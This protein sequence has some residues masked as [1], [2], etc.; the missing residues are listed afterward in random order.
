MIKLKNLIKEVLG[1]REFEHDLIDIQSE[2][3]QEWWSGQKHQS[4]KLVPARDLIITWNTFVKYGRADK[5]RVEKIWDIVKK[6][7]IKMAVNSDWWRNSDGTDLFGKENPDEITSQDWERFA[8]FMSDRSGSNLWRGTGDAPGGQGRYSDVINHLIDLLLQG[9]SAT[10]PE[11]RLLSI[12]KILMVVHGSGSI[13]KWYIEGGVSTLNKLRDIDVKGIKLQGKLSESKKPNSRLGLCYELSGRYVSGHPESILVHGKITNPFAKGLPEVEHAWIEIGN[14]ILDPVMDLTWPKNIYEDFF[15]AKI[16]KKYSFM[17]TI[18]IT[19]KTGNWGPWEELKESMEDDLKHQK[20]LQSTGFWGKRGAGALIMARTTGRILLQLRGDY[21]EQPRTWGVWGGAID[22][23]LSPESAMKQEI[24]QES[25]LKNSQI[26]ETT[27]LYVFSH[28]NGFKYYNFLII[29]DN[30]FIPKPS[31]SAEFEMNGFRWIEYGQWPSPLHF[32]LK[33]LLQ[34]SGNKIKKI[35]DRN[36]KGK[37][38]TE[39]I[40]KNHEKAAIEAIRYVWRLMPSEDRF[41]EYQFS[42]WMSNDEPTQDFILELAKRLYPEDSDAFYT[43]FNKDILPTLEKL[44]TIRNERIKRKI[45]NDPLFLLKM[46]VKN[47]SWE[48]AKQSLMTVSPAAGW[49]YKGGRITD[50]EAEQMFNRLYKIAMGQTMYDE[51]YIGNSPRLSDL[52]TD[53]NNVQETLFIHHL[54]GW[55]AKKFPDKVKVYRGTNSPL[56]KIRPGDFV[57]F[58]KDYARTYTKSKFG[59]VQQDILLAKD[60]RVFKMDPERD[61]MIYWPEGHAIKQVTDIPTFKEFWNSWRY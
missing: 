18:K 9:Y 55:N 24:E 40:D 53:H 49:G 21:V 48:G 56:A 37:I 50:N 5:N 33:L 23:G 2:M 52:S 28:P 13:A 31:Q 25:G 54:S 34:H 43:F 12:D 8:T 19:D 15:K 58:D 16:Y 26:R 10:T 44:E 17:D 60:L 6:C 57:S 4:W 59:T 45:G 22:A 30:E 29:V 32:G 47:K 36:S 27:P 11:E 41:Y 35:I 14:E 42:L 20:Y 7:T 51:K 39:I 46:S 38:L 61:E 1:N 3:E